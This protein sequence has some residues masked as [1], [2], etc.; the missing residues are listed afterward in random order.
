M[1]F[2]RGHPRSRKR[3]RD[4]RQNPPT[5]EDIYTHLLFTVTLEHVV[6]EMKHCYTQS[7]QDAPKYKEGGMIW[8]NLQNNT[9]RC[10]IKK[11][12]HKWLGPFKVAKAIS[13]AAVKLNHTGSLKGCPIIISLDT[14]SQTL[15]PHRAA[16]SLGC[17]LTP[18]CKAS[19]IKRCGAARS[20]LHF[21]FQV[22]LKP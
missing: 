2:P 22:V 11:L 13:P 3:P 18:S 4:Y 21:I 15:L 9:T 10:P 5:A 20:P 6:N 14:P 16:L 12:D 7:W 8:L 1:P 19:P 17:I